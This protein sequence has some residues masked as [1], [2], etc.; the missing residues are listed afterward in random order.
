MRSDETKNLQSAAE[1]KQSALW[2]QGDYVLYQM[3][4]ILI[5]EVSMMLTFLNDRQPSVRENTL[6]DWL[7]N[8]R[9]EIERQ[10]QDCLRK[11]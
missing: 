11:D 7:W 1:A 5:D 6:F 8:L 10:A 3:I 2:Q 9:E 4:R